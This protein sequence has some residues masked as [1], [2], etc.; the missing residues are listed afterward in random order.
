MLPSC[1]RRSEKKQV[2]DLALTTVSVGH[3]NEIEEDEG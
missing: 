1:R 3:A 2:D